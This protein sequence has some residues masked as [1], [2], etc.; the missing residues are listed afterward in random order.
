M[1][2]TFIKI[3]GIKKRLN[4]LFW[5][6]LLATILTFSCAI[7][8]TGGI[9]KD[10]YE[11]DQ[12]ARSI[13]NGKFQLNGVISMWREPIYPLFRASV[14]YV[15]GYSANIILLIQSGL[16]IFSIALISLTVRRIKPNLMLPVAWC[17]SILPSLIF[18]STRHL[19][20]IFAIFFLALGGFI[21]VRLWDSSEIGNNKLHLAFLFGMS[22]GILGLTRALY[23]Y[24]G[25]FAALFFLIFSKVRNKFLITIIIVITSLA[26]MSPW[27]LR[28]HIFFNSYAVTDRV[29]QLLYTR[30][31]KAQASWNQ[32]AVSYGSALIGRVSMIKLVPSVE[33]IFTQT[34]VKTASEVNDMRS[35]GIKQHEAD[36]ELFKKSKEMLF[37]SPMVFLRYI[38]W[39]PID[40][41]RLFSL[42]SPASPDVGIENI[43]H[44]TL[45]KGQNISTN[46]LF[47]IFLTRMAQFL[48]WML[49]IIGFIKLIKN[50]SWNNP[51]ILF[52]SYT[53]I[54]SAP[55]D[56]IPRFAVPIM[57]WIIVVMVGYLIEN[58]KIL[59]L[60]N[61]IMKKSLAVEGNNFP[62]IL[63][64]ENEIR[65]FYSDYSDRILEKRLN[66]PHPLRSY[67][68]KANWFSILDYIKPGDRVLEVGCGEGVLSVLMAKKG[69]VVIATDISEP[70][71]N[72]AKNFAS[73]RGIEKIQFMIA[74]AEDLPFEDNS[75]DVVVADNV[76]E[77]V[78][79]FQRGLREIKRVTR[80]RAIIALPTCLNLCALCLLGGDNFWKISK[81]TIFGLPLGI[82]RFII[83]I[84]KD[85]INEGYAHRKDLPHL[86][87]YPWIMRK[88][89]KKAGFTIKDF[90]AS[91]L[92]MPHLNFLIP[93]IKLL[94][95]H[96]GRKIVNNF[97]YGSI[98]EL[99]K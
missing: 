60:Y 56:N 95:K 42:P 92:C 1:N 61:K 53:A 63:L 44:I 73:L 79:D 2:F 49:I 93:V 45:T 50:K 26:T 38:L 70:N 17:L 40:E 31:V 83:N 88:D 57:P 10:A 23:Q 94:D 3:F 87:R 85:G 33:P 51:A 12:L 13:L 30:V 58:R 55:G 59:F 28:N 24:L 86:W 41:L 25:F 5:P 9:I 89:L 19:T 32:L 75:F 16:S 84:F 71:I 48:W 72:S 64:E 66:S 68:H 22:I 76:L 99:K 81:K 82:L 35:Q 80:D 6:L 14:Y 74:G 96:K 67:V 77:H 21:W 65:K 52:I 39:I 98:A 91:T 8:K 29:G 37:S 97:G 69:A 15:F 90:K 27:L 34:W 54:L 20:E 36:V 18:Y 43:Y 11:Y 46:D 47:I 62:D 78:P 4:P 7:F